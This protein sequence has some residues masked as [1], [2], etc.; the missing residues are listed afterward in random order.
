MTRA[1]VRLASLLA[2]LLA[3]SGTARPLAAQA[4]DTEIWLAP[5]RVEGG[6][7]V[8]GAPANV[9]RRVG[10]DNQPS[11][12]PDGRALLYTSQRDGQTDVYRYD[13]ATRATTAVTATPESEYSPAVSP[14]ERWLTV[15]RVEADSAQRLW[16]FPLDGRGTPQLLL[17][18]VRPVGYFAW[19]DASTIALF[20]LG[21]DGAPNTLQ[22]ARVRD[23]GGTDTVMSGIGRSLHRVPGT[24]TVSFVHAAATPRVINVLDPAT[25]AVRR[26]AAPLEDSEDFA[27]LDG[28]RLLM[29]R[30]DT[31][32]QHGPGGDDWRAVA[33]LGTGGRVTRLAVSPRGD[34]LA[35]VV[36][37][38]RAAPSPARDSA[39]R[40]STRPRPRR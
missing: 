15:V 14:D 19:A 35:F 18:D 3:A 6:V 34:W 16:R 26:I 1:T 20:V 30:R 9:T 33:P 24:A 13:L 25:Q 21:A 31:L 11:F 36:E 2:P 37:P 38:A 22:V 17:R 29:A 28:E 39:A 7:A 27:W 40:D 32:F 4:P 12:T 10:Y 8:V 5:L 23:G